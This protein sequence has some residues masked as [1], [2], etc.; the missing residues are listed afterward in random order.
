VL[1][2]VIPQLKEIFMLWHQITL[3]NEVSDSIRIKFDH[4]K[5]ETLGS[6][7]FDV[8]HSPP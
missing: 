2:S 8:K 1:G 5:V 6:V 3:E 7:C 4:L